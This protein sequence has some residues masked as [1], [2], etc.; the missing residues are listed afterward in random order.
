VNFQWL[1]KIFTIPNAAFLELF[2]NDVVA[3]LYAL[4]ADINTGPGDQLADFMLALAA[5]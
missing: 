2:T 5:E 4:V 3:Q 1:G